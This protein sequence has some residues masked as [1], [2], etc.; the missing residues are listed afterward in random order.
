MKPKGGGAMPS[1]LEKRIIADFGSV[2]KFKEDFIQAG[3][4]QFGSGWAWLAIQ[5]GKLVVTKSATILFS[6]A[7]GIA[8]PPLGFMQFQ[9]KI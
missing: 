4:T 7:L 2:E 9:N 3:I 6:N 5:N 8:P 1:T